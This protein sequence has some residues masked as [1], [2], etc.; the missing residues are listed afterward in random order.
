MAVVHN[1]LPRITKSGLGVLGPA[2]GLAALAATLRKA[3]SVALGPL[4]AQVLPAESS[5]SLLCCMLT[6]GP[7]MHPNDVSAAVSAP[8]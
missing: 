5:C 2:V 1:L 6:H 4:P 8:T 3:A 7:S